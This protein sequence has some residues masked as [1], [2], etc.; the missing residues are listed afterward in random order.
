[1]KIDTIK[2]T[3]GKSEKESDRFACTL[4]FKGQSPEDY[5]YT[6]KI[7][8]KTKKEAVEIL[9][10]MCKLMPDKCQKGERE[11]ELKNKNSMK[12]HY[13]SSEQDTIPIIIE[14]NNQAR[15]SR[16][17]SKYREEKNPSKRI[18]LFRTRSEKKEAPDS[19][20]SAEKEQPLRKVT[21]SNKNK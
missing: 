19:L 20:I 18:E 10:E 8:L 11:V 21:T 3:I 9:L 15:L 7:L 13:F 5:T 1:M 16:T 12:L 4:N 2:F 6:Y 14:S 17:S